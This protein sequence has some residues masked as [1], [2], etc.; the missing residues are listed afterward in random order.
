MPI[1]F[2]VA[3]LAAVN[4]DPRYAMLS[5][6]FTVG[7]ISATIASSL[8]MRELQ[9]GRWLQHLGRY[10]LEIYLVHTVAAAGVRVVLL[11]VA[12]TNAVAPHFILGSIVGVF[13][14][15][16]LARTLER[17]GF[18]WAFRLPATFPRPSP[19]RARLR[20]GSA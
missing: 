17:V 9:L 4:L 13:V 8:L 3:A 2:A 18:E 14:P 12:H 6:A 1:G 20:N 15:L 5:V 11:K 7:G 19:S 16:L 10:S